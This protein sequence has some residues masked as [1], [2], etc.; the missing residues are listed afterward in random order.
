MK[1]KSAIARKLAKKMGIPVINLKACK[2]VNIKDLLGP[3]KLKT[4]SDIVKEHAKKKGIPVIDIKLS[5]NDLSDIKGMPMHWPNSKKLDEPAAVKP[6]PQFKPGDKVRVPGFNGLVTYE[7]TMPDGKRA[8]LTWPSGLKE[9]SVKVADLR[10]ATH[11][12]LSNGAVVPLVDEPATVKPQDILVGDTVQY[13]DEGAEAQT[14]TNDFW[15]IHKGDTGTVVS[16]GNSAGEVSAKVN[17]KGHVVTIL[18][19]ALKVI[20]RTVNPLDLPGGAKSWLLALD[21]SG[22]IDDEA[23]QPGGALYRFLA[24][25]MTEFKYKVGFT[26]TFDAEIL[27]KYVGM[28]DT[29]YMDF[30]TGNGG[31]DIDCVLGLAHVNG[32]KNILLFSDGMFAVDK[33]KLKGLNVLIVKH[34]DGPA[35]DLLE[36]YGDVLPQVESVTPSIKAVIGGKQVILTT[37]DNKVTI[38]CA[39][40]GHVM[41]EITN[42]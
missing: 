2:K 1:T 36:S 29:G 24:N 8:M 13:T 20:S 33:E 25:H 31:T 11:E 10:H 6:Q 21:M 39:G 30:K 38:T 26:V 14:T 15:Y 3:S 40:C 9:V 34:P 37:N 27:Y 4:K 12:F 17:I 5:K 22:S 18:T 23:R 28:P 32:Y 19:R 41:Q 7:G 16:L 42:I 35:K